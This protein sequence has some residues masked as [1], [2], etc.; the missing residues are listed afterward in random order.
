MIKK[1]AGLAGLAVGVVA[2]A[3]WALPDGT[4]SSIVQARQQ[5]F[6]LQPNDHICIIGNTLAER[7]Q[8][9]RLAGDDAPG[10]VPEAPAGRPQPGL[11]R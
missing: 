3:L 2:L 10:A 4:T 9:R 5:P 8:Y 1:R 6:A 7:L 11:Q